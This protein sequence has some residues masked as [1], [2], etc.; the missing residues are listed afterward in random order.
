MDINDSKIKNISNI[1]IIEEKHC[2]PSETIKGTTREV[3][4]DIMKPW[5]KGYKAQGKLSKGSELFVGNLSVE[6]IE[7][8]LY[9]VFQ[10]Y[11]EI[12]DVSITF[13]LLNN[14]SHSF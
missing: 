9:N 10:S 1:S 11:G 14:S 6:T 8:D 12:I 2:P 13:T 4:Y 3:N 7:E 5:E